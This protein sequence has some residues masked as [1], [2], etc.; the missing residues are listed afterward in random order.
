MIKVNGTNVEVSGAIEEVIAEFIY[1][2]DG[3]S[4]KA[5]EIAG[6]TKANNLPHKIQTIK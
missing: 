6:Q 3:V 2:A 5:S 1:L 4:N